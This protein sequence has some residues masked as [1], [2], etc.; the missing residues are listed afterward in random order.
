[1]GVNLFIKTRALRSLLDAT[2]EKLLIDYESASTFWPGRVHLTHLTIR[3]RDTNVE[4]NVSLDDADVVIG[5]FALMK[6]EFHAERVRGD[7]V[8]FRLRQRLEK[9]EATP[10]L[11]AA[12]PPIPG[13]DDP[14]MR[15]VPSLA[16]SVDE[17]KMWHVVIEDV[18]VNVREVWIDPYRNAGH[19]RAQGKFS[20]Q[21]L[22]SV[23]VGPA[24]LD[25]ID[26]EVA[27]GKDVV[28][29]AL[30]GEV[31]CTMRAFDP[32]ATK[33]AA[34]LGTLT[35][36]VQLDGELVS[37]EFINQY[38]GGDPHFS[39]GKGPLHS[40]VRVRDGAI[41]NGSTMRA[42]TAGVIVSSGEYGATIDSIFTVLVSPSKTGK[43]EA[44]AK[45]EGSL[46]IARK[47]FESSPLHA[48]GVV[49][50]AH[51]PDLDLAHA[52]KGTTYSFDAGKT[53]VPDVRMFTSYM[54][55]KGALQ[56]LGGKAHA[57]AHLDL[58]PATSAAH[59]EAAID[60]EALGIR[61]QK[62]QG[63]ITTAALRFKLTAKD[64]EKALDLSGSSIDL[65]DVEI[66]Q[67]GPHPFW[68]G[69][70]D[71]ADTQITLAGGPTFHAV[72]S[73]RCRD[74][75]PVLALLRAEVPG[76]VR[77]LT[78]LE[79]LTSSATLR[80]AAN[81]TNVSPLHAQG[82]GFD[83]E[84][85]YHAKNGQDHGL[86]LIQKSFLSVGI[87]TQN[88]STGIHP[89]FASAWYHDH[90]NGVAQLH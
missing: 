19:S 72:V 3:G 15:G 77:G 83:L 56:L 82:S 20:I 73:N 25:V 54:D 43:S 32:R 51:V 71:F 23:S 44:L 65:K 6:R 88:G 42:Q 5:L 66:A 26:G 80:I 49:V 39:H 55:P 70:A 52:L 86:F 64:F 31:D 89:F 24:H 22:R 50:Q 53:E 61:V 46:S 58:A 10:T 9:A 78:S 40:S 79:A 34:I 67:E 90:A 27:V 87:E 17:E 38:T 59:G 75:R 45:S 63:S 13:F 28:I 37:T 33:G 7:G 4:W 57:T 36:G 21:P 16:A 1:M 8:S 12:L 85:S 2:P 74:G 68:W 35:A 41:E 62:T 60:V 11:V 29:N 14:P 30:K 48:S 84:G 18:D 69:H 76:W 47:G 81:D